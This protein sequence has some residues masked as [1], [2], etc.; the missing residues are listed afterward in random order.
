VADGTSA[1]LQNNV[2]TEMIQKLVHLTGMD[3]A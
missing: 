1:E 3:A 2:V